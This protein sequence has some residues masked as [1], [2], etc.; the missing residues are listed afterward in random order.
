MWYPEESISYCANCDLDVPV[1][2]FW[3]GRGLII[4][5]EGRRERTTMLNSMCPECGERQST[6]LDGPWWHR[7]LYQWLWQMRYPR[8]RPPRRRLPAEDLAPPLRRRR[9]G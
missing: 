1:D 6:G 9:T 4:H 7:A 2:C 8:T 3:R 5:D